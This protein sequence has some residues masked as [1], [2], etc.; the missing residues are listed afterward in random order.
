M[1]PPLFIWHG[2][3]ASG[4]GCNK[5]TTYTVLAE[6]FTQATGKIKALTEKEEGG[7]E[8]ELVV[9][10]LECREQVDA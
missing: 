2:D 8:M 7:E 9:T 4:Y 6:T 3:V 1:N 10:R 5:Y